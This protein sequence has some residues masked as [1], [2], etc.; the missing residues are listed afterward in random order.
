MWR[1]QFF[2]RA[3]LVCLDVVGVIVIF[4]LDFLTE[5]SFLSTVVRE[6]LTE[7]LALA[8]K[9]RLGA[10]YSASSV[11]RKRVAILQMRRDTDFGEVTP[12]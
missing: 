6:D 1:L 5:T 4:D 11:E 7:A 12:G 2:R 9:S 8:L 10:P 3:W